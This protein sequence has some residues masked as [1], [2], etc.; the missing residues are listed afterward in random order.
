MFTLANLIN[1]DIFNNDV[2]SPYCVA[3]IDRMV[4]ELSV[5]QE[6]EGSRCSLN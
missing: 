4:V 1:Y 3:L 2:N 6:A 5:G